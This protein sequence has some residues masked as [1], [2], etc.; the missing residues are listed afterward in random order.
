M[1]DCLITNRTVSSGGTGTL[2]SEHVWG[3]AS[4][5][6]STGTSYAEKTITMT[7]LAGKTYEISTNAVGSTGGGGTPSNYAGSNW[8]LSAITLTVSG[9]T[10]TNTDILTNSV[11]Q[12]T[13][14][15]YR[16]D[17]VVVG[18]SDV[19]I[20]ATARNTGFYGVAVNINMFA[21]T[22]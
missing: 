3:R 17:T 7:L 9:A 19:V 14:Y 8:N 20:S 13:C 6:E 21:V 22:V 16:V 12:N 4:T 18:A 15:S 1:G 2:I 5:T 10:I 11:S